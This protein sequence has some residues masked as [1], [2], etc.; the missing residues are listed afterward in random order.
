M[1][2]KNRTSTR[3][4]F[5]SS[6][7]APAVGYPTRHFRLNVQRTSSAE[8]ALR[9]LVSANTSPYEQGPFPR[10]RQRCW[11]RR[12]HKEALTLRS[13]DQRPYAETRQ[14]SFPRRGRTGRASSQESWHR[15]RWDCR[16][17]L[18]TDAPNGTAPSTRSTIMSWLGRLVSALIVPFLVID[19]VMQIVELVPAVEEIVQ[20][21]YLGVSMFGLVFVLLCSA[22]FFVVPRNGLFGEFL[23]IG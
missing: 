4:R 18:P 9:P 11:P 10:D 21:G 19:S 20:L 8:C 2:Y 13:H 17:Q 22:L 1:T 15:A 16:V 12:S 23:F 7:P 6:T 3:K 5:A 14:A